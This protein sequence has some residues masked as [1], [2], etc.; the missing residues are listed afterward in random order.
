MVID[1]WECPEG[2]NIVSVPAHYPRRLG[3]L[4]T[5]VKV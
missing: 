2:Y 4:F 1:L 3:V 5:M